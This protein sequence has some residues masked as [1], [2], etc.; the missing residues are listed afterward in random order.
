MELAMK[1]TDESS[2]KDPPN[3][4]SDDDPFNLA[5]YN[6]RPVEPM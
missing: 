4:S 1:P 5:E 3:I 2:Y 6:L